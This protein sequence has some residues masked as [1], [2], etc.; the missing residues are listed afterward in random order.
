[1]PAAKVYAKV[2]LVMQG[3]SCSNFYILVV[4]SYYVEIRVTALLN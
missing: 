4:M 3:L 2:Y 1:M